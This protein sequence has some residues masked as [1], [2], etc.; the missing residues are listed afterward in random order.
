MFRLNEENYFSN[1]ANLINSTISTKVFTD[2][3]IF[4]TSLKRVIGFEASTH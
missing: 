2:I 3:K 4:L 1:E